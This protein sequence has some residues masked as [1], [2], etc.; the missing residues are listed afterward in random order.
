MDCRKKFLEEKMNKKIK[1]EI[2]KK[3]H[4]GNRENSWNDCICGSRYSHSIECR[5][6]H[7]KNQVKKYIIS[8]KVKRH[9]LR[10]N[11]M[12]IYNCGRKAEKEVIWHQCCRK[13]RKHKQ[14]YDNAF[15]KRMKKNKSSFKQEEL[16]KI[17]QNYPVFSGSMKDITTS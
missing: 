10:K 11:H 5:I 1:E 13:H 7:R 3:Q 17:S 14:E 9:E 15:N 16:E 6:N 8:N 2:K 4:E 12:C